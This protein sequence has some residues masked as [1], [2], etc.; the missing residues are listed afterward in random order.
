MRHKLVLATALVI[1]VVAVLMLPLV[2]I[3]PT[4]YAKAGPP[5]K[6][7]WSRNPITA[8]LSTGATYA[9]TVTFTSTVTLT[10]VT[11]QLTPSL[12]GTTTISP[13]T[14]TTISAGVPYTVKI[15]VAI[16]AKTMQRAFSG[17]LMVRTG[18]RAYAAPLLLRFAVQH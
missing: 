13:T 18:H 11:L 4:V 2:T 12:K 5:A 8:T 9:T 15:A 3:T 6:I 14:F 10:K 16:P 1:A 7:T 17:A